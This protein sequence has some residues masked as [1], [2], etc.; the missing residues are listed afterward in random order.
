MWLLALRMPTADV[1]WSGLQTL[2]GTAAMRPCPSK[3]YVRACIW[4]RGKPT[5]LRTVM[6]TPMLKPE[7][8]RIHYTAKLRFFKLHA[9][10]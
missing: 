3:G 7:T 8:S 4:D 9:M 2:E 1:V 10:T 5:K 6:V